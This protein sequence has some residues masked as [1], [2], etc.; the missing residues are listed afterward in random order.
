[1]FSV[2]KNVSSLDSVEMDAV[3][4]ALG[5]VTVIATVALPAACWLSVTVNAMLCTPRA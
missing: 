3:G 5:R 2:V 4:G 1:M